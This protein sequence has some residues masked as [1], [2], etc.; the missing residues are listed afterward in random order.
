MQ[1][2]FRCQTRVGTAVV[3]LKEGEYVFVKKFVPVNGIGRFAETSHTPKGV[4]FKAKRDLLLV[5]HERGKPQ[6]GQQNSIQVEDIFFVQL[7]RRKEPGTTQLCL[8]SA[9]KWER[10]EESIP[11]AVLGAAY[12][13]PDC[14]NALLYRDER[15]SLLGTAMPARPVYGKK[16][17]LTAA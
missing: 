16:R 6:W 13:G 8:A 7:N 2:L 12:V 14:T 1:V 5:V 11:H 15:E 4:N 3:L 10:L 9:R 17:S